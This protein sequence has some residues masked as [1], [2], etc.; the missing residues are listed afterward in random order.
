MPNTQQIAC[1]TAANHRAGNPKTTAPGFAR[2]VALD[3]V[4]APRRSLC[5]FNLA[6]CAR[7]KGFSYV[8]A[9]MSRV[10]TPIT[11]DTMVRRPG[12]RRLFASGCGH[13]GPKTRHGQPHHSDRRHLQKTFHLGFPTGS[14]L[15]AFAQRDGVDAL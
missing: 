2:S 13:I 3:G 14:P 9:I 12:L 15:G 4:S 6:G 10:V 11:L 8:L 7:L 1:F 5:P